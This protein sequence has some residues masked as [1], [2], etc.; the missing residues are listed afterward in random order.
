MS[1]QRT[2]NHAGGAKCISDEL[3]Q[4]AAQAVYDDD[5]R[6]QRIAELAARLGLV[7]YHLQV[8]LDRLER[9]ERSYR[10]LWGLLAGAWLCLGVLVL[11]HALS[12]L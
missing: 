6:G 3:Q 12:G 8:R 11:L 10:R 7:A 2:P 5:E 9:E 1:P 4:L